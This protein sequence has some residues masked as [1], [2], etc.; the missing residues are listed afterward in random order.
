MLVTW[1]RVMVL[2]MER[3]LNCR[4]TRRQ[5]GQ[6]YHGTRPRAED[7]KRLLHCKDEHSNSSLGG[8]ILS[9]VLK[10]GALGTT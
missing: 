1:E 7:T 5:S 8:K 2:R 4:D 3:R 6:G 9:K 10:L